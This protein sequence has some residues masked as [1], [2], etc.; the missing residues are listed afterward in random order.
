[1][2][3]LCANRPVSS[4]H[5]QLLKEVVGK[6]DPQLVVL[7]KQSI[8]GDNNQTAQMLCTHHGTHHAPA[9]VAA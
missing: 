8:D 5:A 4:A 6:V 1:M 9:A 3:S 2:C 7:G